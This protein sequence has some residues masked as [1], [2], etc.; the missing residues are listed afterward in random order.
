[1]N[2]H[3]CLKLEYIS[4]LCFLGEALWNTSYSN[5][6][7]PHIGISLHDNNTKCMESF[8]HMI[9]LRWLILDL[10]S[11]LD[12]DQILTLSSYELQR[13]S[14]LC[15][16]MEIH[17]TKHRHTIRIDHE[18]VHKACL[19]IDYHFVPL[20]SSC[21]L[22]VLLNLN[23]LFALCVDQYRKIYYLFIMIASWR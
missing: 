17:P 7:K 12:D 15:K 18:L 20:G 13:S 1:M 16:L 14:F 23:L 22:S 9:S 6:G 21:M 4:S 5:M 11:Y 2:D 19:A 10:T 3:A 8:K